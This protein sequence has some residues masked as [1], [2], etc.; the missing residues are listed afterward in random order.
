MGAELIY[1][2]EQGQLLRS[3][4]VSEHGY[5]DSL[6]LTIEQVH[7]FSRGLLTCCPQSNA[8]FEAKPRTI[9]QLACIMNIAIMTRG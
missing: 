3:T 4:T 2:Y 8:Q 7:V 1:G 5:W 6:L 9:D